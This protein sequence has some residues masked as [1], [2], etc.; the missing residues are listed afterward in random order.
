MSK[1]FDFLQRCHEGRPTE[2]DVEL[3][4]FGA[5]RLMDLMNRIEDRKSPV[6]IFLRDDLSLAAAPASSG[7]E[8]MQMGMVELDAPI[9]FSLS[10]GE[11]EAL[12]LF[13]DLVS[14]LYKKQ[15]SGLLTPD[16]IQLVEDFFAED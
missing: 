3:G 9:R 15:A 1:H 16:N 2:S 7:L 5:K 4:T 14:D 13:L 6:R 11:S 12:D 10:D 8:S